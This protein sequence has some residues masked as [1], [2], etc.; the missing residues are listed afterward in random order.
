MLVWIS[1]H[2]FRFCGVQWFPNMGVGNLVDPF[3]N[4]ST[5]S[6]MHAQI[7]ALQKSNY[8]LHVEMQAKE[9]QAQAITDARQRAVGLLQETNMTEIE[10]FTVRTAD[11]ERS[12]EQLENEI[13]TMHADAEAARKVKVQVCFFH[14]GSVD[15]H[16]R[17]AVSHRL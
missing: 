6:H 5:L 15:P 7:S 8:G 17:L 16:A 12:N 2:L 11:L 4:M 1:I 14:M 9:A 3:P 10:K 13:L